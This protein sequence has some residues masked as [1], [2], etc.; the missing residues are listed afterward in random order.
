MIGL[1]ARLF[2][3]GEPS[4]GEARPGDA[5]ALA[6]MHALAFHHAWSEPE[7]ERL[8]SDRAVLAHVARARGGGRAMIGFVLSRLVPDEAEILMVAVAPN[9]QGR[10]LG[11]KLLSRHLGRLASLGVSRVF[12]EVEESNEP[13]IRLYQ[14]AGF[15]QVGRRPGYYPRDDARRAA[16]VLRREIG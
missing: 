11:R 13:A 10:G 5:A 2:R 4:I 16:L 9:E 15:R 6:S 1:L 7:F 12:L 8:L 14:R 3:R